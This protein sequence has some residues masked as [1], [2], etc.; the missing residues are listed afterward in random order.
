MKFLLT[1]PLFLFVCSIG[2]TNTG[3]ENEYNCFEFESSCGETGIMCVHKDD[4]SEDVAD[5]AEAFDEYICG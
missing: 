3:M 2:Y 4:S 1:L 5:D